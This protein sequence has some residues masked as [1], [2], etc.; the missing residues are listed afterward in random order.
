ML[1][2]NTFW[3]ELATY[4]PIKNVADGL[5]NYREAANAGATIQDRRAEDLREKLATGQSDE[6]YWKQRAIDQAE[7]DRAIIDYYN[8]Q[9]KQ[10]LEWERKASKDARNEDAKFWQEQ[11]ELTR[12]KEEEDRQAIAD[13]WE[14]YRKQAQKAADAQRPS[15]LNFGLL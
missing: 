13:F 6:D 7:E 2:D 11:A 10:Q 3:E 15:N 4:I 5:E 8:E 14:A 9:R 1:A 12:K